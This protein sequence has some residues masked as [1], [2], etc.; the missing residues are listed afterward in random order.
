[1]LNATGLFFTLSFAS[2]DSL[3]LLNNKSNHS[4]YTYIFAKFVDDQK[5]IIAIQNNKKAS[6]NYFFEFAILFNDNLHYFMEK[7]S[8]STTQPLISEKNVVSSN[9]IPSNYKTKCK[10]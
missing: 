1:M 2:S 6:K 10:I 5:N 7:L 8:P 9:V 3:Y 4:A